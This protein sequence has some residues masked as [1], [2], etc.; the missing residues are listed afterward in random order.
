MNQKNN[1]SILPIWLG[2]TLLLIFAL[3]AVGCKSNTPYSASFASVE[4]K[5]RTPKEIYNAI[6]AVFK[7]DGYTL[8]AKTSEFLVFEEEGSR[9]DK[10]AYGSWV[11]ETP[12]Y[13]R[14]KVSMVSLAEENAWRIQC[15]AYMVRDKGAMLEDEVK[16]PNRRSK[17]FQNLLD[18]VAD[19][20][21]KQP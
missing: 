14:V 17:P 9:M 10:L 11:G 6:V 20:L 16:L 8:A 18:K 13:V 19:R 1:R 4:V 2:A 15:N 12:I 7:E 21:D 3:G 5:E